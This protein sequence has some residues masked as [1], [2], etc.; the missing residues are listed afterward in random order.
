M[1]A[2]ADRPNWT[3]EKIAAGLVD[4]SLPIPEAVAMLTLLDIW[5]NRGGS[6]P[7]NTVFR[8]EI[9]RIEARLKAAGQSVSAMCVEAGL[10]RSTWD[11]WKREETQPN[12]KSWRAVNDAVAR[13]LADHPTTP[14]AEDAA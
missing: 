1:S 12:L 11:R 9:D 2:T 10:A 14:L 6:T 5:E 7:A 13:L 4:R 3:R 8:P